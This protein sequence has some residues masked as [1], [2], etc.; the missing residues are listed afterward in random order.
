HRDERQAHRR[1][2][3]P[4][5]GRRLR[6]LP[7][8]A[9]PDPPGRRGD[10]AGLLHH[11]L[12]PLRRTDAHETRGRPFRAGRCRFLQSTSRHRSPPATRSASPVMYAETSDARNTTAGA[13]SV[14]RPI[15]PSGAVDS[16]HARMSLSVMPALRT[17]SVSISPGLTA[18]TRMPRRPSPF[19]SEPVITSTAPFVPAYTDAL[20]GMT[21]V[22]AELTLTMLAPGPIRFTASR[23]TSSSPSTL[24]SY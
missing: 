12:N 22:I 24:M 15:R 20:G 18:F 4:A 23:V 14:T 13:M 16:T 11:P 21:A 17:P 2:G 5:Q 9:L 10:R 1:A 6:R 19:A 8:E 7:Q 3:R